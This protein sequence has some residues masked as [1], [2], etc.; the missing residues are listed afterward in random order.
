M[1]FAVIVQIFI[2]AFFGN[3]FV[4]YGLIPNYFTLLTEVLIY[5]LLCYALFLRSVKGLIVRLDLWQFYLAFILIAASSAVFNGSLDLRFI[6]GIRPVL[7]FYIF[8]LAVIN[9]IWDEAQFNKV[10][11]LLY[12][13]FL[14]QLPASALRFCYYGVSELTIGT[15]AGHGGGITP[16]IPIVALGFLSGFYIFWKRKP[17]FIILGIGFILFGIAGAK[18]VLFFLYPITFFGIYYLG[19]VIG[20]KTSFLRKASV[21]CFALI[22]VLVSQF[23]MMKTIVSLNPERKAGGSASYEYVLDYARKYESK[24]DQHSGRAGGRFSTIE[25]TLN[26]LEEAGAGHLFFGFGPGVLTNSAIRSGGKIDM[27]LYPYLNSYGKTGMTHLLMEYGFAGM[28]IF[29]Y[30]FLVFVKRSFSWFKRETEVWWKA[31]AMGTVVFAT[32]QAYVYFLY[33]TTSL[34]G[35]TL[36]PVYFYVMALMFFRINLTRSLCFVNLGEKLE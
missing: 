8:Y 32:I 16:V 15:Y 2:V 11:R 3:L 7:R 25:L 18:R 21:L 24:K 26:T 1:A 23:L 34:L 29:S 30:I 5:F 13:L 22:G 35:D 12:V 17:V 33:N 19:L 31:M 14:L 36:V 10:N 20:K 28:L 9:L 27:K 6:V 4:D